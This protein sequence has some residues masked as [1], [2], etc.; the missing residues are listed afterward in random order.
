[1]DNATGIFEA[2]RPRLISLCYRMLGERAAAED[3]V[4]DTWLRWSEAKPQ[5]VSNPAAW[6]TRVAT[7]IAIDMLR[8]ARMRRET[9]VGPWLPEPLIATEGHPV[10][11]D[12]IQAQECGL[13]MLWAMER[14]DAVERAAFIL[15]D[16]FDADYRDIAEVL[17]K[18]E[19][20]CR[21]LISRARKRVQRGGPRFDVPKAQAAELL[22]RFYAASAAGD[23]EAVK[24]LLAPDV[25]AISDGGANARAV[26]RILQDAADIFR[27]MLAMVDRYRTEPGWS[28]ESCTANGAP[29]LLVRQNG[30]PESVMSLMLDASGR[31][32]W[33]YSM[34]A[35]EK[36]RHVR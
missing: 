32:A 9:Y 1:M 34:R 13:A 23:F 12:F 27:V 16:A 31:V 35:P 33:F 3:A 10:E 22:R 7:N 29:A 2:Q 5:D 21:Q 19:A 4:Q 8:S 25:V 17:G 18:S 36:L 28:L 14:L 20:A 15:R 24:R 30:L 11:D 26:R 6:L